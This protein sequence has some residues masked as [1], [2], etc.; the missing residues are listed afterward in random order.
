MADFGSRTPPRL[1]KQCNW[2]AVRDSPT[3]PPLSQVAAPPPHLLLLPPPLS[4][5]GPFKNPLL[6]QS[7]PDIRSKAD[8]K[9]HVV[10]VT[11]VMARAL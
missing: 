4:F 5:T 10:L 8:V 6:V 7:R 11:A 1:A 2:T 9:E 3:H